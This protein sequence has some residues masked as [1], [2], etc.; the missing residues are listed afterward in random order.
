MSGGDVRIKTKEGETY[1]AATQRPD[2]TWR[3]ARRVK[4]GYVPQ[5]EQPKYEARGE[6]MRREMA[7][8]NQAPRYPVGWTPKQM[9]EGMNARPGRAAASQSAAKSKVTFAPELGPGPS[10]PQK[11]L[12]AVFKPNACI[13][14]QDHLEKKIKNVQK[15]IDEIDKLEARIKRRISKRRS[16]S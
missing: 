13:T 3:K 7:A 1:I 11:P 2:G 14:P 10:G 15:K 12:T 6:Q 9:K 5:D 8:Q 4:E 16:I